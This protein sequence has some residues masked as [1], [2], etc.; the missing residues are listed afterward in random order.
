MMA[1][2]MPNAKLIELPPGPHALFDDE[3][4]SAV[5]EFVCGQSTARTSERVL[6][7]V[8]FTDIVGSTEQLNAKGDS[9]W[10][11][12]LDIHDRVVDD[13]LSKYDRRAK[14]TGDGIFALFDGPTK[15]ARSALDLVQALATF[16]IPIRAGIHTGECERR[17]DE[18][19]GMA[20]HTGARIWGTGWCRRGS[21]E[22]DRA[23]PVRRFGSPF[24][25]SWAAASQGACRGNRSLPSYYT[26]GRPNRVA[27]SR[28]R[29]NPS[30]MMSSTWFARASHSVSSSRVR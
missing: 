9:R 19:S 17:G 6:M 30:R 22:P 29:R 12:R 5:L 21:H 18:W 11:H 26:S 2:G 1:E 28:W 8:L 3:L 27:V 14:H 15:A 4:T 7:S 13:L 23:G 20:V 16:G 25:K 24:R 10:R